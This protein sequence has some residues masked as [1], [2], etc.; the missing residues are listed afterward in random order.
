MGDREF[1]ERAVALAAEHSADGDC[2]PFGAVLVKDG[3]IIAEGWNRVVSGQDPTAHAEVTAIRAACE[4]LDTHELKGCT[5]Y[6]SCEPCPMCFSA[7]VWARVDRIV[8]AET[9]EGAARAGFDDDRLYRALQDCEPGR[10]VRMEHLPLASATR[11]FD[12]W[13]ENDERIDY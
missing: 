7:A 2:G 9:R 10:L 3:R 4:A 1:L 8:Y 5:L 13:L 11:V 12:R 6:S